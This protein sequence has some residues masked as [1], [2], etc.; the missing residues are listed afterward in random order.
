M[1]D[2]SQAWHIAETADVTTASDSVVLYSIS[3][4]PT[5]ENKQQAVLYLQQHKNCCTLDDTPCG[6]ALIALN[7]PN[8]SHQPNEEVMQIW[9][10]ASKRFIQA[11]SGN[12]TAFVTGADKR[13]TFVSVELP[14]LL[15][16]DK[17]YK[18]NGQDKFIFAKQFA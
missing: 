9:A 14:L 17:I 4:L 8:D 3:Y 7:L 5:T 11:A 13:S 12:I 15:Q 6:K 16:N 18:I 10:L 1:F 2:F